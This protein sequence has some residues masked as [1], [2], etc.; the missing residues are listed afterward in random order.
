MSSLRL[1]QGPKEFVDDGV[2]KFCVQW[3]TAQAD[4]NEATIKI[5]EDEV[6]VYAWI[7]Q[8]A[9]VKDVRRNPSKYV[10]SMHNALK[11]LGVLND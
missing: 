2:H 4:K 3:F 9:L 8:D 10:P 5:Q 7:S 6:E 1:I 11:I